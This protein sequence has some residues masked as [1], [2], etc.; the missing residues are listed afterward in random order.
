V[1]FNTTDDDLNDDA[2]DVRLR[3]RD[4]RSTA[5][6]AAAAAGVWLVLMTSFS[7]RTLIGSSDSDVTASKCVK[8]YHGLL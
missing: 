3:R 1:R 8:Y 6:A 2:D 7:C 4:R 5:A